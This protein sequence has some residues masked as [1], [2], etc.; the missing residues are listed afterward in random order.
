[1]PVFEYVCTN[2]ENVEKR[3]AGIDDHTVICDRCGQVS[4]RKAD[5]ESL[6]ASYAPAG[7]GEAKQNG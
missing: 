4:L 6:M 5:V 7:C 3:I 2:C 1:M